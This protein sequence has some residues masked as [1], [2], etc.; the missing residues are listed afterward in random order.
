MRGTPFT[1]TATTPAYGCRNGDLYT[2][3]TLQGHLTM[4][5]ENYI[6][7]TGD[8]LYNNNQ[9]DVLGLV[10]Q[11]AVWIWNPMSNIVDNSGTNNDSGT[12]LL[13]QNRTIYGAILSVAHTFQVQNY[14]VGG[15]RGTLKIVGSIA[16]NFRGTVG[17]GSNGYLEGLRI[18]HPSDLLVAAEVPGADL[19]RVRHD[20]ARRRSCRLHED[21]SPELT[22]AIVGT[23]AGVFGLSIGSFL[24]VVAYR[25]P[26]G[27]SVV[28]PARRAP[29]AGPRSAVATTSRCSAWLM[30]RGHCRDC[31]MKISA[32]YPI[33]EALT[34]AR[35]RAGRAGLRAR[36][37]D[38]V[39]GL[40]WHPRS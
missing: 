10:G 23:F 5:A 19:D 14:H 39:H 30:L 20:A 40:R 24:N 7:V 37:R 11:N 4:A 16:Q 17:M 34:G 29:D 32:R 22:A 31:D 25:V 3:G 12:A 28:R 13:G 26:A 8:I 33:V 2:K 36:D 6:Y 1:S 38:R 18:R 9:Q 15:A 21:G 27:L 35:L